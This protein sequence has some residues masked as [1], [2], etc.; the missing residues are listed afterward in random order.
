MPFI[1]DV[2]DAA[3][4]I[5]KGLSKGAPTIAFPFPLAQL[6]SASRFLPNA[7]F[8]AAVTRAAGR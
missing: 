8:D 5:A 4:L 6:T 7:I 1:M 2:E 3:S